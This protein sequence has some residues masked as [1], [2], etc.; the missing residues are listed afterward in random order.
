M[1]FDHVKFH[2]GNAKQAASYYTTR[3]GFE[4]YAYQVSILKINLEKG[5]ET[6]EREFC[7][8]VVK[9]GNVSYIINNL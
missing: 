1:A 2:V 5:L 8:H 9:N 4:Y 6:G 7:T 3:F